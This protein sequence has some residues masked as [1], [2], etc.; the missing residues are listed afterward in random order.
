MF[1]QKPR[2]SLVSVRTDPCLERETYK[3][4]QTKWPLMPL[5]HPQSNKNK[6]CADVIHSLTHK[7]TSTANPV[8]FF[9]SFCRFFQ[10]SA[11]LQVFLESIFQQL[12]F[13]INVKKKKLKKEKYQQCLSF[14]KGFALWFQLKVPLTVNKKTNSARDSA[15]LHLSIKRF[16]SDLNKVHQF[17]IRCLNVLSAGG[18]RPPPSPLLQ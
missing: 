18:S 5:I 14:E 12:Y 16:E 1:V 17:R 11:N 10:A 8:V 6:R 7:N 3:Y 15:H 4:K 2:P 9:Y 13:Y